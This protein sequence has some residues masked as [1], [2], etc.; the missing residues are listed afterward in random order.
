MLHRLIIILS[1]IVCACGVQAQSIAE[2][3]VL[4]QNPTRH[5]FSTHLAF[6][7]TTP[8][9]S[10]GR[11]TTGGG[12]TLTLAYT[13]Y[14][15]PRWFIS[16][17]VAAFYSTMGT[18]FIPEYDHIY[19]GTVKN[20]GARIPLM[21]GYRINLPYDLSLS[22]ATGPQLNINIY[23]KEHPSPDFNADIIEPGDPIDLFGCGFHRLDLQWG[24][25]AG[26]TYKEHYCLGLSGAAGITN[27]ASMN[28]G[29]RQLNI[30]R[31]NVAFMLIYKF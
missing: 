12:A 28:Q 11:W 31:N 10:Q 13:W 20:Y 18:D 30:R 6:E 7:L 3:P 21:A 15:T 27:V 17:G 9:G 25:F 14:I 2:S 5:G 16:P 23:A 8:T 24:F 4:N 19:E 29:P 22:I 1:C 26:I